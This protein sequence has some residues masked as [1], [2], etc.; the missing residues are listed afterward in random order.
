MRLEKKSKKGQEEI[1]GFVLVVVLV[2]VVFLVFLGISLRQKAP[3]TEK[4][5]G[6]VY[7]FL[8]SAMQ[9]SSECVISSEPAFLNLG[10]LV[11]SCYSGANCISGKSA[12]EVL[13]KTAR[14][15]VESSWKVGADRAVKGYVFNSTYSSEIRNEEIMFIS[16]G[17]CSFN[18]VGAEY[19]FSA[20]P[21]TITVSLKICS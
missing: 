18:M 15:I 10:E 1:V 12:C 16:R 21:G 17:N 19:F 2:A 9:F 6:D 4:E 14:E 13:E 8:E 3:V 20:H 11:K 5:S 7:Q